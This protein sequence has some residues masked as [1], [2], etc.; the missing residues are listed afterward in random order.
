MKCP[1][2]HSRCTHT[3][4]KITPSDCV[5]VI[6]FYYYCKDKETCGWSARFRLDYV[7]TISPSQKGIINEATGKLNRDGNPLFENGLFKPP[8]QDIPANSP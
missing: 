2:C 3:Q 4:K 7:G 8:S 1:F 5:P 6:D